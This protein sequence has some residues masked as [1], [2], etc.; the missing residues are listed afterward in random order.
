MEFTVLLFL[1]PAFTLT[2]QALL[3]SCRG[4]SV[5]LS[6][7]SVKLEVSP[8][9]FAECGKPVSLHCNSSSPQQ[10]LSVKY[11]EWSHGN[12]S[13]C[14]V[15]SEQTITKLQRHFQ[16]DFDCKYEDGRLSL[17]FERMLPLQS[18]EYRC[19]LRSNK[20]VAN[21]CTKVQLQEFCGK[22]E[23]VL[24]SHGP[25]CRFNHVYPDGDVHWFHDSRNVSDESV[26]QHTTKSID[27]HG[28]MIIHS[29]LTLNG[30]SERSSHEPY[31]C[32][33]KSSTSG[34]YI[35][36]TLVQKHE[37]RAVQGA[38]G[39]SRC[40]GNREKSLQAGKI[41]LAILVTLISMLK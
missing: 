1:F 16:S 37:R 23:A 12:M 41:A 4:I 40:A 10:G 20:G 6:P 22:V 8:K 13:L 7:D 21:E 31:N 9:I 5:T 2:M 24:R 3:P 35:A 34:K 28:W 25:S 18:G 19:K 17:V 33:L 38:T 26:M 36:S 11:M 39:Y 15:D 14:S 32:S 27:S 30:T 29:W